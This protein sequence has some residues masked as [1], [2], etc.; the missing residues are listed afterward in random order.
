MRG[1]NAESIARANGENG[2]V[3]CGARRVVA[4]TAPGRGLTRIFCSQRQILLAGTMGRP[5][6]LPPILPNPMNKIIPFSLATVALIASAQAAA[7]PF[8]LT[9][10]ASS[11]PSVGNAPA[12]S[13]TGSGGTNGAGITFDSLTLALSVNVAFGSALGST[14]FFGTVTVQP[15]PA[16]TAPNNGSAFTKTAAIVFN[17]SNA[18]TVV[19]GGN[20]TNSVTLTPAPQKDLSTSKVASSPQTAA[21]PGGGVPLIVAPAIPEPASAALLGLG[22]LLLAARRRRS[23]QA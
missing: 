10:T 17:L 22:T 5:D 13:G 4:G 2:R 20:I 8:I 7:I 11:G 1:E 16:P 9:G 18:I 3:S 21:S 6:T 12:S 23:A 14:N 15:P 19:T